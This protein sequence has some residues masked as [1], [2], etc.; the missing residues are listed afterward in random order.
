MHAARRPRSAQ[1][2][3][4]VGVATDAH[5]A[6]VVEPRRRL[7]RSVSHEQFRRPFPTAGGNWRKPLQPYDPN[8]PRN[9]LARMNPAMPATFVSSLALG[10]RG[11]GYSEVAAARSKT[12]HGVAARAAP[13][14]FAAVTGKRVRTPQGPP[15]PVHAERQ[16]VSQLVPGPRG[17]GLGTDTDGRRRSRRHLASDKPKA[18][19]QPPARLGANSMT[20]ARLRARDFGQLSPPWA[21]HPTEAIRGAPPDQLRSEQAGV[22]QP[23]RHALG[24]AAT[25]PSSRSRVPL[26]APPFERRCGIGLRCLRY[27]ICLEEVTLVSES[28]GRRIKAETNSAILVAIVPLQM[29][30]YP[31]SSDVMVVEATTR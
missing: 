27:A 23:L 17:L 28:D 11:L 18:S 22:Q 4:G 5:A 14:C 21:V 2:R 13:R 16:Q 26:A 9:V 10:P 7:H 12:P 29:R 19:F 24:A 3:L 30:A 20:A 1:S 6:D 25:Q 15:H 31:G 8:A